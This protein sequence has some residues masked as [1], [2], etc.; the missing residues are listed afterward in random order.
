MHSTTDLVRSH[1]GGSRVWRLPKTMRPGTLC[2][3]LNQ[4]PDTTNHQWPCKRRLE[5]TVLSSAIAAATVHSL[6]A[7]R[8]NIKRD[9]LERGTR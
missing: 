9:T 7:T 8:L 2:L 5:F 1:S 4:I 6:F 3:L